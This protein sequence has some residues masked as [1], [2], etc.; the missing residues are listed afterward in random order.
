VPGG[1]RHLARPETKRHL[2]GALADAP[3]TLPALEMI[4]KMLVIKGHNIWL[5][6]G[7]D[8]RR[9]AAVDYITK[10]LEAGALRPV[11][12]RIFT[13]GQMVEAHRYLVQNGQFGK[14]VVIVRS[15]SPAFRTPRTRMNEGVLVGS[16]PKA[17]SS[18]SQHGIVRLPQP[19]R[20]PASGVAQKV[21]RRGEPLGLVGVAQAVEKHLHMASSGERLQEGYFIVVATPILERFRLSGSG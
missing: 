14:I 9:K 8:T 16:P 4:A 10:G 20:R 6:S 11:I 15:R 17:L 12:D 18:I 7:D 1:S 13:F 2:Y 5:T 3:T 21:S 19:R